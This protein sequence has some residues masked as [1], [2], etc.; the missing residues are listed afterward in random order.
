MDRPAE[1]SASRVSSTSVRKWRVWL[2]F[3]SLVAGFALV[4]LASGNFQKFSLIRSA[5]VADGLSSGTSSASSS[6]DRKGVSS[7]ARVAAISATADLAIGSSSGD[8]TDGPSAANLKDGSCTES[9]SIELSFNPTAI[10]EGNVIWFHSAMSVDGLGSDPARI[11]LNNAAITFAANGRNYRLAVPDATITFDPGVTAARTAF[12]AGNNRWATIVPSG[13]S[14]RAF[15]SGLAF[16]VPAD[17]LPAD[18]GAVAWS[19]TF[20]T[21]TPGV[22]AQWQWAAAVYTTFSTDYNALGVMP[23]D[24]G[25]AVRGANLRAQPEDS[26]VAASQ[27]FDCVGKPGNLESF[28]TVGARGEGGS[29]FTGSF[30][31][32]ANVTPCASG[33]SRRTNLTLSARSNPRTGAILATGFNVQKTCPVTVT[34]GQSFSCTFS[35]QNLDAAATVI[36]LA[37]TETVPCPDAPCTGGTTTSASC[38]ISGVPTTVLAANGTAGD[39]CTGSVDETAPPCGGS[40]TFFS[41]KIA[42]TGTDTSIN[43]PVSGSTVNSPR[44]LAC[45]PTPTNTPTNTPTSTPTN[46]PTNTPTRTP[47]RTPTNTPTITPT[48]P[49]CVLPD[50]VTGGGQ[51]PV[52]DPDS[53][54]PTA[55]GTGRA[56]YGFNAKP[57]KNANCATGV[58]GIHADGHFNYLNHVTGLHVNGP[59]TGISKNLD[60]SITFCGVCGPA[61]NP[62]N[63]AFTVTVLDNGEPGTN[64]KFGLVVTGD[65]T[66]N[67]SFRTI[68]RGNIQFHD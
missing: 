10:A 65:L 25:P 59:V 31:P 43:L 14:G 15:V 7:T 13:L 47:T 52:P 12:D 18:V 60:G 41:D 9:S 1:R 39:T 34:S 33:Q 45:T 63:C 4:S 42:A 46:T 54:T 22:R 2:G 67:R 29:D 66:E 5:K 3:L 50:K 16:P 49:S 35:V 17:G 28:V 56:S 62:A 27:E 64:D 23:V 44:L 19:A 21:D 32:A 20:S 61:T 37:V 55:T 57:S 38:N 24:G 36:N 58:C 51:I 40:D 30:G 48:P 26:G 11:L 6:P 53:T 8:R 68:S